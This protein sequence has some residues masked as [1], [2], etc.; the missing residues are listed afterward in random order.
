MSCTITQGFELGCRDN[1]G[2]VRRVHIFAQSALDNTYTFA[3]GGISEISG[4]GNVYTYEQVK[5]TA[6]FTETINS[7]VENGTIFYQQDLNLQFHRM[8]GSLQNQ[9]TLLGQNPALAV[10]LETQNG[11]TNGSG[12]F[13]VLGQYNGLTL[14]A[15]SGQSGTAYGDLNGYTLTFSGQEPF[16]ANEV[17]VSDYAGLKTM[18]DGGGFDTSSMATT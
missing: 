13:F 10:V 14:S 12:R 17:E 18:L 9:L 15:G 2:G 16:P 5:Q 4:S 1:S 7:S 8:S 11:A 3:N 6:N